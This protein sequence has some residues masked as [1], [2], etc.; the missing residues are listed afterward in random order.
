MGVTAGE[1]HSSFVSWTEVGLEWF[2]EAVP[3][4]SRGQTEVDKEDVA[5]V[6]VSGEE[7]V[8]TLDIF[9][10]KAFRM[11]VLIAVDLEKSTRI[12]SRSRTSGTV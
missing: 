10:N 7:Q 5:L 3:S 1:F 11:Q 2:V 12:M 8:G 6:A 9:M 4:E